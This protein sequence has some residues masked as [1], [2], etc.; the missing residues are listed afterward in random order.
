MDQ[1]ALFLLT[2]SQA[3]TFDAGCA[4]ICVDCHAGRIFIRA[5]S[6]M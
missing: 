3:D 2:S 1:T 5:V 6:L 4:P